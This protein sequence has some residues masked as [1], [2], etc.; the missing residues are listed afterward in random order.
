MSKKVAIS[1]LVLAV[2]V[3]SLAYAFDGKGPS[4]RGYGKAR[5]EIL[6]QLP[7]EKEVLFHR[8]M[9]EAREKHVKI[10]RQVR[11][12]KIEM[13][14]ILAAPEFNEELFRAK[15]AEV[16][17]LTRVRHQAME[18]AFIGLAKQYTPEERKILAELLPRGQGS[19]RHGH[20]SLR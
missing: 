9:R 7:V 3:V 14:D 6:S 15:N 20:K 2:A 18:E 12:L 16:Q 19:G 11:T 17:E 10:R 4:R 5:Y 8:A 13:K 1:A